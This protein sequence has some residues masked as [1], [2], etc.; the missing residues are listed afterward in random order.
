MEQDKFKVLLFK[1]AFCTMGCDGEIDELEV[2][3]MRKIDNNTSFFN[4][5]D[6]SRELDVLISAFKDKGTLLVSELFEELKRVEL[7]P[8]QELI[9]LEVALRLIN[10]DGKQDEN[11]KRFVQHLR[12]HLKVHDE[13]IFDRFGQLEILHTSPHANRLKRSGNSKGELDIKMPRHDVLEEVD[14]HFD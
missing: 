2:E 10:A 14:F 3:E 4:N 8:I 11:E 9:I 5:V 7:S 1:I 12:A 6:L 13:E